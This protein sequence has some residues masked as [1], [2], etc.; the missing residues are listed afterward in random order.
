MLAPSGEFSAISWR[1]QVYDGEDDHGE[2]YLIQHNVKKFVSDLR[3][4]SVV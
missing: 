4:A 1:K 3:T 2:V